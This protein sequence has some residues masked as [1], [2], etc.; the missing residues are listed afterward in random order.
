MDQHPV[1]HP[2]GPAPGVN[3]DAEDIQAMLGEEDL[4]LPIGSAVEKPGPFGPPEETKES[5]R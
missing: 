3:M 2:A 1:T 5:L 4:E